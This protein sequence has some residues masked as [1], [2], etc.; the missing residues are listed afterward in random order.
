MKKLECEVKQLIERE[1]MFSRKARLLVCVSGGADS[2]ALLHVMLALGYPCVAVHCNFHLRGAE[3]DR[4]ETFVRDLCRSLDV[5]LFVTHFDTA[6]YAAQHHLSIEMAARE[7]RYNYFHQLKEELHLTHIVVAHHRDDQVETLLLHLLR[8]TGVQGLSGI[9]PVNGEI[10]RPLLRLSRKEI[11]AYLEEMHQTYVTDSTNRDDRFTRNKIRLQLLPLMEEINPSVRET[12]QLFSERM[13]E[14]VALYEGTMAEARKRVT[15]P[16]PLGD[17]FAVDLSLLSQE[18]AP[19]SV[20]FELLRPLGFR[21]EQV[22]QVV[23]LLEGS[24][25]R[26]VSNGTWVAL[27][28]RTQLLVYPMPTKE[29]THFER[30]LRVGE[31]LRLPDG[32]LITLER[33]PWSVEAQVEKLPEVA[34]LDG[35]RCGE[36]LQVRLWHEGDRLIPF[37]MK[38]WKKV[39]D[40]LTD[41]KRSLWQK[42]HQWVVTTAKGDLCWLVKERTDERFRVTDVTKWVWRIRYTAPA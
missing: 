18:T 34:Y 17:G 35:D 39:S 28:D 42:Q 24:S 26:Q 38:G 20:L 12:L 25:G 19:R 32:G 33:L 13:T 1:R 31:T 2:V 7:L 8:G 10:V 5:T 29:L 22:A 27:K 36:E 21:S 4:D 9:R 40:Y 30:P 41:R 3:S 16:L 23:G 6:T 14:V 37:G 15:Q 11:E